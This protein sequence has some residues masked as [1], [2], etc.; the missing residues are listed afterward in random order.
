MASNAFGPRL[1]SNALTFETDA[2]RKGLAK[3]LDTTFPGTNQKVGGFKWGVYAF[4]DFDRE[5]IYV[6]QTKEGLRTRIG[7]HLT[8]QR[9]DAVAMNVLDPFEVFEVA[10]WPLPQQPVRSTDDAVQKLNALER[11]VW[12][13]ATN[14]A[15][16][17][18]VLNEK[19][20]PP[21]PNSA[22]TDG[23]LP[24]CF[25]AAIVSPQV[26]EL[27]GHPDI[28]IARRAETVARLARVVVERR[29]SGGLR[30]TLK[31]QSERLA[32]LA[33]ARFAALGGENSVPTGSEDSPSAS[34]RDDDTE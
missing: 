3:F 32:W 19:D 27:R 4:F 15:R 34:E 8:N 20:P 30:R 11:A 21:V 33:E 29:V 22:Y 17:K 26:D 6:G 14:E 18:A 28:R 10:V 13:F 24:P 5:P 25:R 2:L 12:D 9:T 1:D 31:L 7:R 16:F 23:H